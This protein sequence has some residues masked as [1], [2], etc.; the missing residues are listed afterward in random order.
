MYRLVYKDIRDV[1]WVY[2]DTWEGICVD[3]WGVGLSSALGVSA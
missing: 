1:Y 3:I 2:R